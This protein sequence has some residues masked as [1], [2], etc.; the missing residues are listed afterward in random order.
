M[1]KVH[2]KQLP[3]VVFSIDFPKDPPSSIGDPLKCDFPP[4]LGFTFR[5][6]DGVIQVYTST[7]AE[8]PMQGLPYPNLETY[9]RDM[10]HMCTIMTNGPLLVQMVSN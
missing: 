7:D 8:H 9:I 5:S 10:E 1:I 6:Q 2:E 3:I 4:S